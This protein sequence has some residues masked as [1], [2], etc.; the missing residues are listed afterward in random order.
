MKVYIQLFSTLR[1]C[2]PP[3]AE[4]GRASLDL[5]EGASL[6]ALFDQLGVERCLGK[7]QTFA[8]QIDSWQVSVN[9][10]FTR[11]LSRALQDGDQVVV[12]PHMAG[13]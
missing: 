2:L 6:E 3:E 5:P 12:F 13:G 11:D 4:R 9:G 10:E 1:D 7:G 8:A